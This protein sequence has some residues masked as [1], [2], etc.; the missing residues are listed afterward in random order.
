MNYFLIS[1]R[2]YND[3]FL[4]KQIVQID[5]KDSE[6]SLFN[7]IGEQIEFGKIKNINQKFKN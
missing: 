5:V 1:K 7:R 4:N 2:I 6:L 3:K